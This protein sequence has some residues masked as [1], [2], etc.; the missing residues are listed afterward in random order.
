MTKPIKQSSFT[1][2]SYQ[3]GDWTQTC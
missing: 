1:N 2:G 3:A